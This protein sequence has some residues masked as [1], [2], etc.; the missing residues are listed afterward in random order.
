MQH[1]SSFVDAGKGSSHTVTEGES[2][3]PL[4]WARV[5]AVGGT[6]LIGTPLVAPVV[7]VVAA[8]IMDGRPRFDYLIPG[9]LVAVVFA[10]AT[11]L[12]GAA[13]LARQFRW[14]SAVGLVLIVAL[15][16]LIGLTA[17][18]TGLASGEARA[19]GWPLGLVASM[20]SLYV[21]AVLADTVVGALLC[22]RLFTIGSR[23]T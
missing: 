10:G 2:H 19:E 1:E 12:L 13:V 23:R 6:V 8:L 16:A 15:F 17:D 4:L 14:A 3:V 5:L 18:S 22:R 9:E 21:L 20:Y 7:L 11:G